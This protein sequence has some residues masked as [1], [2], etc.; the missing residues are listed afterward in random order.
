M[1]ASGTL[2]DKVIIE[3]GTNGTFTEAAGQSLIDSIGSDKQIYW[4][5]TYGPSLSWYSDVNSVISTLCTKNSNV[6][7]INWESTGLAHPEY[8]SGDGIHL[9]SAGYQ[10]FAQLMYNA[11][12]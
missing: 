3:L 12:K 11:V 5:N 10:A 6:S 9:T 4:M 2:G 8:F 7:L 1:K